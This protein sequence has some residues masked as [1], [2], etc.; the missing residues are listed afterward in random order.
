MLLTTEPSPQS[1]TAIFQNFYQSSDH[2]KDKTLNITS[3]LCFVLIF[4]YANH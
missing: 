2:L 1:C 4:F 3:L